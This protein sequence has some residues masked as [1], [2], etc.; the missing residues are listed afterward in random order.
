[1]ESEPIIQVESLS[2]SFTRYRRSSGLRGAIRAFFHREFDV[3]EAV[4]N[5]AFDIAPGEF[6][7]FIGPNGAG[8]T[9]TMKMLSGILYPTGGQIQVLG[10]TPQERRSD[11]LKQISFIMGQKETLFREL[12][13]M[14]LFLLMRDMYEIPHRDF[15]RALDTLSGL[16][17]A[18]DYLDVQV[19]QLSLGQRMKC[20]LM[21]GLL[22]M[23]KV[24]F[25]DEPT[26]GLDIASQ[27]MIRDF[28]RRYN[29]ETGATILLTSHYLEDIKSLCQRIIF[30]DRG[31][32]LFDGPLTE[33]MERYA[34]TVHI[35]FRANDEKKLD[36]FTDLGHI[37]A[38]EFDDQTNTYRVHVERSEA[39]EVARRLLNAY[40]VSSILIEEPT[41]EEVVTAMG[42]RLVG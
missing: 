2:R 11:F 13:A 30:I 26:I 16:L 12:P 19:R 34:S 5:I 20:E 3:H 39:D 32:L 33:I 17:D 40:S 18:R 41:L 9:T 35:S 37:G 4:K 29:D 28:F 21:S 10:Y 14:E 1:M 38:P 7:G 23:P 6:V 36:T 15:E 42:A 25:L 31:T 8:K 24:L 22:H 27:K